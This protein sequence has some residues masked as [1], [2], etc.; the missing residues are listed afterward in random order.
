M[1]YNIYTESKDSDATEAETQYKY[2]PI[3]RAKHN[4]I[5]T[6]NAVHGH[7]NSTDNLIYMYDISS[8]DLQ[9]P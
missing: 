8:T 7:I 1:P 4:T 3:S 2:K 6:I 5:T 9:N